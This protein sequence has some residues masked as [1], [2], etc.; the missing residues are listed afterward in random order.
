MFMILAF[1]TSLKMKFQI[2]KFVIVIDLIFEYT[3]ILE[4]LFFGVYFKI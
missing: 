4:L 2:L 1:I 3:P